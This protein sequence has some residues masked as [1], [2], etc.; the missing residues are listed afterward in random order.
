MSRPNIGDRF[1]IGAVGDAEKGHV[2][3]GKTFSSE[4]EGVNVEGTMPDRGAVII[5][6]GTSNKAIPA[7]YHNGAGYVKGDSNL[8]SDN[9]VEGVS[10][11]GVNG[12]AK[13]VVTGSFSMKRGLK[14]I[15]IG[16]TPRFILCSL[17]DPP[18][19]ALCFRNQN[20]NYQYGK[21]NDA[22]KIIT[23]G[24]TYIELQLGNIGSATYYGIY[25]ACE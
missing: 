3:E 16:F 12:E 10:I 2:L 23:L 4:V 24:S 19:W 17:D 21:A 8:V 22:F 1:P 20:G 6:P 25:W 14:T 9:I 11:F 15:T 7:G 13:K 18:Y 5:T